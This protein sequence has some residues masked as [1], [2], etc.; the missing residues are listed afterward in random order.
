MKLVQ[1]RKSDYVSPQIDLLRISLDVLSSSN[2]EDYDNG[3]DTIEWG[4]AGI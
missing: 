3:N 4:V 1:S 2:M